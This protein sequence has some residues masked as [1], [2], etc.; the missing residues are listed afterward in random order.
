MWV[1]DLALDDCEV[2]DTGVTVGRGGDD[3][4]GPDEGA[5]GR[6]ASLEKTVMLKGLDGREWTTFADS[7]ATAAPLVTTLRVWG[8]P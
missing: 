4:Y 6:I 3:T 5:F 8:L 1:D 2:P 7:P